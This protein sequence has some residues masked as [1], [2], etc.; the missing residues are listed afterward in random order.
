MRKRCTASK[1]Q[2]A[3]PYGEELHLK[4]WNSYSVWGIIKV[5]ACLGVE[6]WESTPE[7]N[8]SGE[9][10]QPHGSAA[11][12][13]QLL[14]ETEPR[15]EEI[16]IDDDEDCDQSEKD[17]ERNSDRYVADPEKSIAE[18][19]DDVEERIHVRDVLCRSR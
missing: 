19:I 2:A 7:M 15:A 4:E 17:G 1:I 9:R 11:V 12:L 14:L 10:E 16:E 3:S 13:M 8:R 18:S 5:E 6:F